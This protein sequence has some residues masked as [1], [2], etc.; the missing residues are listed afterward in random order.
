MDGG[1]SEMEKPPEHTELRVGDFVRHEGR[2]WQIVGMEPDTQ[3][4]RLCPIPEI[5]GTEPSGKVH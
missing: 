5:N 4:L 1:M 2:W 3:Q